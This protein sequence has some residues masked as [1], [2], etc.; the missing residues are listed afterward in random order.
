MHRLGNQ[1]KIGIKSLR[2]LAI[3]APDFLAKCGFVTGMAIFLWWLSFRLSHNN[4][5]LVG[6]AINYMN[7]VFVVM[8]AR[9]RRIRHCLP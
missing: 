4:L 8:A 7:V 5:G 6:V 3:A 9:Q 1:H 2:L